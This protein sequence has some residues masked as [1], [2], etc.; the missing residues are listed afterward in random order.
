MYNKFQIFFDLF[1]VTSFI[2]NAGLSPDWNGRLGWFCAAC[3]ALI[4]FLNDINL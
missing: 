2:V 1:C 4:A 3:W